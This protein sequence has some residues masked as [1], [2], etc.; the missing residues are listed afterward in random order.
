MSDGTARTT[1]CDH[2]N[3]PPVPF[4]AEA[5]KGK[6]SSWVRKHYPRLYQV[7]P[8]CQAEI[9]SYASSEHYYAGDY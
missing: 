4:D 3:L 1:Q 5:C 9:I 7:C 6:A 2:P 8:D